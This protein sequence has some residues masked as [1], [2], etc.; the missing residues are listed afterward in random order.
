[1]IERASQMPL[2]QKTELSR[3]IDLNISFGQLISQLGDLIGLRRWPM[4]T[5]RTDGLDFRLLGRQFKI[6]TD[7]HPAQWQ[8]GSSINVDDFAEADSSA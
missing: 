6:I 3:Q 8:T 4:Q 2:G 1:M 7:R 5:E